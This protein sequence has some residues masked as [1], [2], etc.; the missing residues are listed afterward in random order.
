MSPPI[1]DKRFKRN[2]DIGPLYQWKRYDCVFTAS[3]YT[4]L[5]KREGYNILDS[6][7]HDENNVIRF[8]FHGNGFC[9]RSAITNTQ[10][11]SEPDAIK[12]PSTVFDRILVGSVV[13]SGSI[14]KHNDIYKLKVVSETKN[15]N[16]IC[17]VATVNDNEFIL[18]SIN[19]NT[20][21]YAICGYIGKINIAVEEDAIHFY[22]V[23]NTI[24]TGYEGSILR[25]I[26][27][28]KT[29]ENRFWLQL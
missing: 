16:S 25:L 14:M 5:E 17:N 26:I 11:P 13:P 20:I 19:R 23:E 15:I 18:S 29:S 2:I 8:H 28:K 7:E 10:T 24:K 1:E 6:I 4:S 27:Q 22:F 9:L 21:F 12:N 3:S